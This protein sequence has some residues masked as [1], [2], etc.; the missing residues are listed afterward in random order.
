MSRRRRSK[1]A[2]KPAASGAPKHMTA[3]AIAMSWPPTA[4]DTSSECTMSFSAPGTTITPQ[5]MA[6]LPASS[7]Q[8]DCGERRAHRNTFSASGLMMFVGWP[9][10][11]LTTLSNA[12]R[13]VHLVAVQL[14]V[15]DVRRA[16][17]VLEPQQR[18]AL[19]H[20]L[21]LE[22]VDR[23]HA[24]PA[25]VERR[26]EGAF[27][28]Q[29]GAR[30][31]DEQRGRLHAQQVVELDDGPRARR[32]PQVQ[33]E[34]VAGF[35]ERL[36][37]RRRHVAVEPGAVA[38]RLAAPDDDVHAEGLA[39]AGDDLADLAVAPDAER[40]AARAPCRGRSSAASTPSFSP[41]CCHAPCLRLPMYCGSRRIEAMISAQVSSAGATGEPTPSAT[42][43]PKPRAASTSMCGPTRPVCAMSLSLG[44]FSSSCFG[45]CVRSR[46]GTSTSAS[47]SRTDNCPMPLTV[48]VKTLAFRCSSFDAH[49]SLRTASW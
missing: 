41:D 13:E 7:A 14:D 46:M 17:R 29:L 38:R 8:R 24:G 30:R 42:A 20:R 28:D 25:L 35:E 21:G 44:S 45:N 12:A 43:M 47:R 4:T 32:Q 36:A 34:H 22:H 2:T 9:L 49:F 48:L 39:V 15:A 16:H 19:Q 26:D 27:F 3:A 11:K 6:K 1:P 23:R 10:T 18:V 5:P 40:L 37:R 31:V 33:A